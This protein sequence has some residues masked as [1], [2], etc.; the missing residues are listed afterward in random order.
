MISTLIT[1][2]LL[3]LAV[4]VYLNISFL[5]EKKDFERKLATL[6]EVIVTIAKVQEGKQEQVQLSEELKQSLKARNGILNEAI[7]GLNFDLFELLS[8]NNL[9]K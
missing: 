3:L 8:K 2:I 1:I 4:I 9:L 5:K 7:F 6:K